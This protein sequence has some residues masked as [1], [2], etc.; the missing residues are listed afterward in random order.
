MAA[1][2]PNAAPVS[3]PPAKKQLEMVWPLSL[4]GKAPP[5]EPRAGYACRP[6][7]PGD[8]Q[9]FFRVMSLA[10]FEGWNEEKLT[11]WRA[12]ILPDG[13]FMAIH[14]A[15]NQIVATTMATHNPLDR[16]PFGG[17]LGWV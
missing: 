11:P 9:G 10:G 13:W 14:Q 6:Y 2:T 7:Q 12:K 8:E 5:V 16:H 3:A 17:E 15:S 1:P 4:L